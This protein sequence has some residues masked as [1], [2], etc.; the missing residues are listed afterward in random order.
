MKRGSTMKR[1]VL[2]LAA[3]SCLLAQQGLIFIPGSTSSSGSGGSGLITFSSNVVLSAGTT[4]IFVPLGGGG[5]GSTTEADVQDK[6]QP[7]AISRNLC[8]NLSTAPGMGNSLVFTLRDAGAD[9]TLTVTISNTATSGCDT[10]HS[11]TNAAGDLMDWKIVPSGVIGGYAPNVMITSEWAGSAGGGTLTSIAT[12]CGLSGGTITISGTIIRKPTPRVVSGT[13]DAILDAD[14]GNQLQYTNAGLVSLTIAQAGSGGLFLSGWFTDFLC[15]GAAGCTLTPAT[16][17]VNNA[18]TLH[19]ATNQ[20]ARLWSD[21]SQYWANVGSS[22]GSAPTTNQNIRT[23]GAS[24]GAFQSGATALSGSLTYC[25]PTYFA[26]T[27]QSV[28]L[29]GDVSG[30][31]TVDVQT[32]AHTSWTGTASASSI[33]AA[34]IPALVSAARY[35]DS[36]L[37]GWTTSFTAGTDVCFVMT[38]PTTVA[39][40]S[41][42]VKVAAN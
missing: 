32:V 11:V 14:C 38:S 36:T 39:G 37:T 15:T 17:T 21:G 3:A 7:I 9:T 30:S 25:V 5:L 19:L 35:T 18:A 34:A 28:E 10:T 33:T 40:V 41:I 8:V 6:V 1:L 29:I 4:P 23:I 2:F 42:T 22:T 24:F 26:G 13:S 12:G 27:I 31:V 20:S 16:S